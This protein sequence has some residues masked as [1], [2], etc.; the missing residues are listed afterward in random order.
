[1]A[2]FLVDEDLSRPLAMAL[3]EA[4]LEADDVR[5]LG[6]RGRP[7]DEVFAYALAHGC[8]TVTRDLGFARL[9]RQAPAGHPAVVLVRFPNDLLSRAINERVV[10]A[11]RLVSRQ[12]LADTVVVIEPGRMRLRKK[13]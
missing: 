8:V 9:A 4:A 1:M 6:L 10:R 7:D 13:D 11:L 3:R 5:D 2:R 12:S